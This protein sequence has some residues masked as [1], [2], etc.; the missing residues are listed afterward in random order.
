MNL[1]TGL[2]ESYQL[3][4]CQPFTSSQVKSRQFWAML[5]HRRYKGWAFGGGFDVVGVQFRALLHQ[6][7]ETR[8]VHISAFE[9]IDFSDV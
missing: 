1:R 3:S 9:Q 6:N 4:I 8:I 2:H 7:G 5:G